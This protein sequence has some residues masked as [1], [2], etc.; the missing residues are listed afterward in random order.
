MDFTKRREILTPRGYRPRED[1]PEGGDAI[2]TKHGKP[3]APATGGGSGKA[4]DGREGELFVKSFI[5]KTLGNEI[6]VQRKAASA[7]V[8][9]TDGSLTIKLQ[10]GVMNMAHASLSQHTPAVQSE[11]ATQGTGLSPV[12]F[13]GD[14]IFCIDY[15]GQP[16][17]PMRPIVENMGLVWAAQSVKLNANKERWGV[18]MIETPSAGGDQKMLSMPVRKLPAWLNSINPKKVAPELRE[19]IELYQAECDDALWNYWMN[20]RAFRSPQPFPLTPFPPVKILPK[21]RRDQLNELVLAKLTDVPPAFVWKTRMSIWA[22]FNTHFGIPRYN[23]LPEERMPEAI[24]FLS[25]LQPAPDGKVKRRSSQLSLPVG[26]V[27]QTIS[28]LSVL[29]ERAQSILAAFP[30]N[31]GGGNHD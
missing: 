25:E 9:S 3:Q 18:S 20:G 13:H 29:I 19:K 8:S 6:P 27:R 12:S 7:S 24:S 1:V 17:T 31:M 26:D 28:S 14:T 30:A 23:L 2:S 15:Q 22:A 5:G 11:T 16:Y 10:H 4:R 21:S